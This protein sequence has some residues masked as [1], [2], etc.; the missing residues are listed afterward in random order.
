MRGCPGLFCFEWCRGKP[1]PICR[2][3]AKPTL[4][5]LSSAKISTKQRTEGEEGAFP[6]GSPAFWARKINGKIARLSLASAIRVNSQNQQVSARKVALGRSPVWHRL[7]NSGCPEANAPLSTPAGSTSAH[8]SA[9]QQFQRQ[10]G[11]CQLGRSIPSPSG[12]R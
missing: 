11:R 6:R 10:A 12:P 9:C 3:P 4:P 1:R 2:G 5:T 7:T 8:E